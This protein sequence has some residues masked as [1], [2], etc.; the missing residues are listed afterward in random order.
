MSTVDQFTGPQGKQHLAT[1]LSSHEI[2]GHNEALAHKFAEEA[3]VEEFKSGQT[4]LK[5]NA[6]DN[7]VYLIVNGEVAI[8][9]NGKRVASSGPGV[10]IGEMALLDAQGGRSASAIAL[11]DTVVARLTQAKFEALAREYP[12]IWRGIATQLARHVRRHN[13]RF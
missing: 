9:V 1:A 6:P 12:Q 5:Q 7:H 2:I 10:L 3:T 8:D 11:K 4:L 13:A